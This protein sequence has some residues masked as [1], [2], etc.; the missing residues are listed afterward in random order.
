MSAEDMM[1]ALDNF[2]DTADKSSN[3]AW[4]AYRF[5]GDGVRLSTW[6]IELSWETPFGDSVY[7]AEDTSL[8]IALRK[9]FKELGELGKAIREGYDD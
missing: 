7:K 2:V 9:L 1:A 6:A 3:A 5:R 8:E 4:D